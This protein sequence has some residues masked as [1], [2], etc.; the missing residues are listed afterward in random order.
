VQLKAWQ[1]CTVCVRLA[2]CAVMLSCWK[3]AQWRNSILSFVCWSERITHLYVRC[4]TVMCMRMSA[5][6]VQVEWGEV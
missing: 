5:A 6:G 2:Q 1:V 4:S 3:L